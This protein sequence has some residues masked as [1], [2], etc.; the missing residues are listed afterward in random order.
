MGTLGVW[1]ISREKSRFWDWSAS[2]MVRTLL[3]SHPILMSWKLI[4]R[5]WWNETDLW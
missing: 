2:A 1:T 5:Y 3:L 4:I